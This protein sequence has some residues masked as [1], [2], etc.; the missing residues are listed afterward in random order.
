[1]GKVVV[2][3]FKRRGLVDIRYL[4]DP[5]KLLKR[6]SIMVFFMASILSPLDLSHLAYNSFWA[7]V[8]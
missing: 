4:L 8:L 6:Y 1:M 2:L 7:A 5:D 3:R